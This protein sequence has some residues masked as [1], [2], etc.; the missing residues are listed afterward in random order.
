MAEA[1][2]N[3]RRGESWEAYSAGT[4]PADRPNPHALKALGEIGIIT[5]GSQPQHLSDYVGQPFD[6]VATV[7]DD[8]N[9]TCPMWPGQGKRVHIGFPDPAGATG[10]ED[11]VMA[12]YRAVRDDIEHK[13]LELIDEETPVG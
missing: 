13:L 2:I 3:A 6:L 11:E 7:C 12:V 4:Q 9:E 5:E 1:I 10:S 8:A